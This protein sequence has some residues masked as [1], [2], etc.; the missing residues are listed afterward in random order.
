MVG[1]KLTF[2]QTF[3][4]CGIRYIQYEWIFLYIIEYKYIL[5]TNI[6]IHLCIYVYSKY[7]KCDKSFKILFFC[8]MKKGDSNE[9]ASLGLSY[10]NVC[11]NHCSFVSQAYTHPSDK[12]TDQSNQLSSNQANGGFWHIRFVW[13]SKHKLFMQY[14]YR[15][16]YLHY[17]NLLFYFYYDFVNK[18]HGYIN[19]KK[20]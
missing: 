20:M 4:G 19:Y 14:T 2:I 12:P 8:L 10:F 11:C 5:L 17:F 7:K 16:T 3:N 6:Y 1:I 18:L 15:H 13:F 9:T